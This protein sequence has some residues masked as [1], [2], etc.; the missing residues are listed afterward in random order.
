MSTGLEIEIIDVHNE[1]RGRLILEGHEER[2]RSLTMM[3]RRTKI[4]AKSKSY[5]N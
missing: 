5:G 3:A 1:D 2:I 4:L